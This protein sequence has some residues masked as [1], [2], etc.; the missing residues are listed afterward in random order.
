[1]PSS[2]DTYPSFQNLILGCYWDLVQNE[3]LTK[4][5]CYLPRLNRMWSNSPSRA[6]FHHWME[7]T[8][9][10]LSN[11]E[12]NMHIE[13]GIGKVRGYTKLREQVS[14]IRMVP[15]IALLI[16]FQF[17]FMTLWEIICGSNV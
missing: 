11:Q 5:P 2:V 13:T 12:M 10:P 3:C 17:I 1:M 15:A 14:Q 9:C 6:V 7:I 16:L 8:L 4:L